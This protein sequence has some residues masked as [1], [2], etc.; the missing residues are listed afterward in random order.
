MDRRACD[1]WGLQATKR[2]VATRSR[3][4]SQFT[5]P[6]TVR[7]DLL[8]AFEQ[9]YYYDFMVSSYFLCYRKPVIDDADD[10]LREHL[11]FVGCT[12]DFVGNLEAKIDI[13]LLSR[14]A[15]TF[16]DC[17]LVLVGST[18]A[19]PEVKSLLRYPNVRMPGVVPYD[20]L[21]AWLSGFDVGLIPHRRMELTRHMNPLKA[22]VYLAN[23]VPVVVTAVPNIEPVPGLLTLATDTETSIAA[24]SDCLADGRPPRERFEAFSK[25]HGWATRLGPHLDAIGLGTAEKE[26]A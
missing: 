8:D 22:Y 24:V 4:A 21:G 3:P 19:N 14:L 1:W 11:A 23:G 10:A 26:Q 5:R 15:E 17:R 2:I 6:I 25:T 7:M 13:P 12:L 9:E 18:H 20:R 16:P